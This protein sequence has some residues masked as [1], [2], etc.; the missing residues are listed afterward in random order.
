MNTVLTGTIT[1]DPELRIAPSGKSLCTFH[2]M[3]DMN[4]DKTISCQAWEELGET[5]ITR[6][7]KYKRGAEVTVTGYYKTCGFNGKFYRGFIVKSI[8]TY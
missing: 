4:V 1:Y 2:L 5:I 6:D 7:D 3:V 8:H